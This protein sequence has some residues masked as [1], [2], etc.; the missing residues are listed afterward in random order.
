MP[1]DGKPGADELSAFLF[2][3]LAGVELLT[4]DRL[5]DDVRRVLWLSLVAEVSGQEA[6][7]VLSLDGRARELAACFDD[8]RLTTA[9][10]AI[11]YARAA[12]W[13]AARRTPATIQ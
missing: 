12:L 7:D 2:G 5:L 10:A 1:D 13:E 6:S 11:S 4:A 3:E 9:N 8:V